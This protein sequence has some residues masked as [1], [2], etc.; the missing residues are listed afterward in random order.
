M[1]TLELFVALIEL[2]AAAA[3][4]GLVAWLIA[5]LR[6]ELRPRLP[7]FRAA[8]CNG[9]CACGC[10]CDAHRWEPE[11]YEYCAELGHGVYP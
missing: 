10:T 6:P 5:L 11:D 7:A 9:S 8:R 2:G 4:L 3:L 1:L